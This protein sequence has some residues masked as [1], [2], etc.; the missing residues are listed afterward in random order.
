MH[1][2]HRAHEADNGESPAGSL[3]RK[4]YVAEERN[5]VLQHQL[6]MYMSEAFIA[7]SAIDQ[8]VRQ[9]NELDGEA[10]PEEITSN[11]SLVLTK[12]PQLDAAEA[13]AAALAEALLASE[14]A[15]DS[16]LAE[17]DRLAG[18]L[19]HFAA[20][21]QAERRTSEM[22]HLRAE[23]GEALPD[24]RRPAKELHAL[25]RQEGWMHDMS[26]FAVHVQ[27]SL[28]QGSNPGDER[29]FKF[30]TAG[31]LDQVLCRTRL[32]VEDV[33]A[34][35]RA[36]EEVAEEL[37]QK[38]AEWVERARSTEGQL[39]ELEQ[40]EAEWV[41]RARFTDSELRKVRQQLAVTWE[42]MQQ[43]MECAPTL[44]SQ[45]GAL[46]QTPRALAAVGGGEPEACSRRQNCNGAG[47]GT[48]EDEHFSP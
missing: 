1:V 15:L 17:H 14:L 40:K 38:E 19:A 37:A 24:G 47:D 7:Q 32:A 41:E 34:R 26:D 48:S 30:S 44:D 11:G 36:V 9:V 20:E 21:Y 3:E 6:E 8:C 35:G 28:S 18:E 12:D 4:L 23:L 2:V 29:L 5:A 33:E 45:R 13:E 46:P 39:R 22:G 27:N 43:A 25:P 10:A 16:A 31:E 42:H